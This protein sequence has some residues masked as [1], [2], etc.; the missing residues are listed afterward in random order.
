MPEYN[1]EWHDKV[2][3]FYIFSDYDVLWI[4]DGMVHLRSNIDG[5]EVAYNFKTVEELM[6]TGQ[7]RK[8]VVTLGLR[9]IAET[10]ARNLVAWDN[11]K[12]KSEGLLPEVYLRNKIIYK[13]LTGREYR[14]MDAIRLFNI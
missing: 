13:E 1:K 12:D 9:S 11:S 6:Q 8:Q 14:Q 5:Q 7:G 3:D 10:I 2:R 4:T